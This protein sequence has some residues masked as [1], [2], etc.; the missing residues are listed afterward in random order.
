MSKEKKNKPVLP[1]Y[2]IAA[3]W[4]LLS[5]RS[6][7]ASMFR[8]IWAVVLSVIVYNV[9]KGIIGD[10]DKD[11][12]TAAPKAGKAAKAAAEQEAPKKAEPTYPPEVQAVVDEGKKARSELQRLYQSIPDLTV[13]KKVQEIMDVSDKIITD[14]IEDPGDVPQIKRFLDYYLPTTI[15]LLHTYDRMGNQGIAGDNISGTMTRI[16]DMLDTAIAAYKKQLDALFANQALDIET[17]IEVMNAMLAREGLG[18]T[19]TSP[20]SSF[21]NTSS[22]GTDS[23]K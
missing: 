19:Q 3:V 21:R 16:E 18:G 13:K 14:A 2:A 11:D 9:V 10:K 12:G 23:T 20:F 4:L 17:D 15:K 8:I 7:I 6:P 1:I 5:I 22:G